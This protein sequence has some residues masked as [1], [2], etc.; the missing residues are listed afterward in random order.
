MKYLLAL[1]ALAACGDNPSSSLPDGSLADAAVDAAPLPPRA[2]VVAGDFT[3]GHPG[4][5]SALDVEARTM[6]TNVGPA[7]A[8]GNDPVVRV[9]DGKLYVINRTDNNVTIL[10]A[11]TLQL[12]EQL[13]TGAGSNP[14][15]VAVLGSTLYVPALGGKGLVTL[16]RGSTAV[17][18]IDLSADD[19]D[20]KP[21]CNSVYRVGSDLYVSCGL[22]DDTQQFLPPRGPGKV[23]VLDSASGAI[24]QTITLSTKNPIG[25]FEQVPATAVHGGELVIPTVDFAT[26]EGC[27]ERVVT[28]ATAQAAGCLV[29]NAA[30]GNFASRIELAGTMM[31]LIVPAQDY[32]HSDLRGFELAGESLWPDAIN[33]TSQVIQD[34]AACADGAVV[35]ADSTMSASGL[36][37]YEGTTEK[38]TAPLPIGLRPQAQH[39]LVC[40]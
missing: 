40:Y 26:G 16:V 35:V 28:G 27:V 4:V 37:V 23:Y 3:A 11:L 33:P 2:V 18:E 17:T 9:F 25:L 1:L 39:G 12:V 29:T 8:V 36:R 38:T 22:L 31:W 15:D 21:N 20:G 30:L 6:M 24:K 19:P 32:V 14:Q 10:D 5:L 13:G 7:M 34:V